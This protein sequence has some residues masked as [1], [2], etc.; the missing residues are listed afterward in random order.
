MGRS[1]YVNLSCTIVRAILVCMHSKDMA[2]YRRFLYIYTLISKTYNSMACIPYLTLSFI[3][4]FIFD[5]YSLLHPINL[6]TCTLV[7][8]V[9]YAW[10]FSILYG[11]TDLYSF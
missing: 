10:L 2:I 8:A 3:L 9:Q 7:Y 5:V 6:L 11:I 4:V 1:K